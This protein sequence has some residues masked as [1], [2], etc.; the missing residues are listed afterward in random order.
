MSDTGVVRYC[1]YPD[2]SFTA[3]GKYL[4]EALKEYDWVFTTKSF[5]TKDLQKQLGI[6]LR[7]YLPHA[8]DPDVHHPRKVTP[9]VWQAFGCDVSFIGGWSPKKEHILE[10]LITKR[11][12]LNLKIW[13]DRWQNLRAE[14]PLRPYT[15]FRAIMGIGYATAISCSKINLGLLQDNIPGASQGDRITSRTFHIPAC[16]GLLLHE[17]TPDLLDIFTEDEDCACFE[18]I[19]ELVQKIDELLANEANELP[20]AAS[21]YALVTSA[22]SRDHRVNH[23]LEH[24]FAHATETGRKLARIDRQVAI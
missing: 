23:I 10:Q 22:H 8:Y 7:S 2:L 14:S 19:D 16:G 20:F 6:T 1:Y 18:T 15:Q 12:Q 11:P 21:G 3:Y 5:G 17:R 9:A 24:Y 4:P 13:G